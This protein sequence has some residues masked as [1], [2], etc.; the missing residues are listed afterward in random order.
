MLRIFRQD[1]SG[2]SMWVLNAVTDVLIRERG[3]LDT[4][5]KAVKLEA[6]TGVL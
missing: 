4:E 1:Y 2:L 3:R 5:G 6:E